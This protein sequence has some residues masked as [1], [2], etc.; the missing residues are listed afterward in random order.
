MSRIPRP[1]H[2]A[3][4]CALAAAFAMALP[5]ATPLAQRFTS[6]SPPVNLGPVVNSAAFD[7]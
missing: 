3:I 2:L 7:G 4:G 1:H 5:A 6:W